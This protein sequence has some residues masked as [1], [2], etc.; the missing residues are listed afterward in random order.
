MAVAVA[1]SGVS[2]PSCKP[3]KDQLAWIATRLRWVLDA[4]YLTRFLTHHSPDHPY[5]LHRGVHFHD[6]RVTTGITDHKNSSAHWKSTWFLPQRH[7]RR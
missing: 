3:T 1:G 6:Q 7:Q 2:I 5:G 4:F